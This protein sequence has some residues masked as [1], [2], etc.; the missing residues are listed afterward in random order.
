M[1]NWVTKNWK[2]IA[3]VILGLIPTLVFVYSFRLAPFSKKPDDWETFAVY[4][5]E[6][7]ELY[8]LS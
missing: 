1:I 7:Q 3:G 4:F 8:S 6:Q 5:G 2:V